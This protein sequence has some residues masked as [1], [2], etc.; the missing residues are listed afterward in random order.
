M[1]VDTPRVGMRVDTPSV[2]MKVDTPMVG[3][4]VPVDTIVPVDIFV[5]YVHYDF[6]Q[7]I[8]GLPEI[9]QFDYVASTFEILV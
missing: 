7:A 3:T 1:K 5:V 9:H 2:G 6:H 8:V 4:T